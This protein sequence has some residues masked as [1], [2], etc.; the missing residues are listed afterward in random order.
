AAVV[1]ETVYPLLPRSAG[2]REQFSR[3][4]TLFVR[5]MLLVSIPGA[6]FVGIEGPTLSRV[7]Y[8]AKWIAA[9]SLILPSTIFAWSIS[10]VLIF[11]T[12]LQARNQLGL[13]LISR[14]IAAAS[15]LPAMLVAITGG[16][17]LCYCLGRGVGQTVSARGVR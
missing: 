10:T 7:L 13:A 1:V 4:A 16:R 14:L 9:D 3:H 8:G 11:A 17:T 6:M 2:D 15:C 5:T 12:D